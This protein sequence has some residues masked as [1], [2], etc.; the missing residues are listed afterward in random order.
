MCDPARPERQLYGRGDVRGD[1]RRCQEQVHPQPERQQE[2]VGRE[3]ETP[4]AGRQ[5]WVCE[6]CVTLTLVSL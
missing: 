5:L 4:A 3:A 6:F 1:A 2:H